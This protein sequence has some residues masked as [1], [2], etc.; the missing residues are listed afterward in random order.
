MNAE[1]AREVLYQVQD[2]VSA[3]SN[4]RV[5]QEVIDLLDDLEM[6][7]R[8]WATPAMKSLAYYVTHAH[9]VRARRIYIIPPLDLLSV[10][11][12]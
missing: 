4:K 9:I 7:G 11:N 1:K 12:A 3:P 2:K 10:S 6:E 5:I 8:I